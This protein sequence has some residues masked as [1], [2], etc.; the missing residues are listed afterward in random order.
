MEGCTRVMGGCFITGQAA[1]VAAALCARY[2]ASPLELDVAL[3][4]RTLREQGA[5]IPNPAAPTCPPRP[6][7][8]HYTQ[9]AIRNTGSA[10]RPTKE[11]TP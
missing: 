3:L 11:D 2:D 8:L 5:Y 1:G 4:Q 10:P 6:P 9:H 7:V